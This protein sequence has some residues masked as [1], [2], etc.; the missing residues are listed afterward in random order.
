M[1]NY[2]ILFKAKKL[3]ACMAHTLDFVLFSKM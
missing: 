3:E 2:T 1:M